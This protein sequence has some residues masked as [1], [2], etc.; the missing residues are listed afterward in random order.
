MAL[1]VVCGEDWSIPLEVDQS[2]CA[3]L[4]LQKQRAEEAKRAGLFAALVSRS[5]IDALKGVL[6]TD[7]RLPTDAQI[8]LA[9]LISRELGVAIPSEAL[10]YRGAMEDY[11]STYRH[12]HLRSW[13]QRENE[14]LEWHS[15]L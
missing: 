8:N 5:F 11:L 13:N 12:A 9:I 15:N 1:K 10:K 6:G 7:L 14:A 2:V 4:T 3:L